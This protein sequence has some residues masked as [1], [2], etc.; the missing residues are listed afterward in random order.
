MGYPPEI[1]NAIPGDR[2]LPRRS[3]LQRLWDRAVVPLVELFRRRKRTRADAPAAFG[4]GVDPRR[5]P[6]SAAERARLDV[7]HLTDHLTDEVSDDLTD[8]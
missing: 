4:Q 3:A 5:P 6:I 2:L 8:R 1:P 7:D